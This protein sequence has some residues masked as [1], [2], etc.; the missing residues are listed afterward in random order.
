MRL[1][2]LL[3]D[4]RQYLTLR[5]TFHPI[6][7]PGN[8]PSLEHFHSWCEMLATV[9]Q[10]EMDLALVD[11][12]LGSPGNEPRPNLPAL[13][14]LAERMAR[15]R[16][17]HYLKNGAADAGSVQDLGR[18]GYP[19]L[20]VQGVD[21]DPRSLM[22]ILARAEARMGL[23]EALDRTGAGRIDE[24]RVRLL[25]E[26]VAG[27]PPVDKV[28]ILARR[29]RLGERTLRRKFREAR[30]PPPSRC[31][32]WGRLLETCVHRRRAVG[33][34]SRIAGIVGFCDA[35]GLAHLASRLTNRPLEEVWSGKPVEDL[36]D[37]L[38][39]EVSQGDDVA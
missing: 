29:L 27:W 4:Q 10:G 31:L 38:A 21:D 35:A 13:D 1:A 14:S 33:S 23:K 25:L 32:A 24:D 6:H 34:K 19:Y 36:L 8:P 9:D 11:P 20:L 12:S 5:R 18:L 7:G 16:I 2:V 39:R 15:D 26:A 30:L 28:P 17:I 37:H 22:R 3:E